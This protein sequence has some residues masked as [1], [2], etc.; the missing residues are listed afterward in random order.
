[1]REDH[2]EFLEIYYFTPSEFEK[3]GAAWPIRMGRN[4]VKPN[5]HMR[6][7][8]APCYYLIFIMDG[9]GTF[10]QQGRTYPLRKHDMFALFPQVTREYYTDQ[11]KPL[12]QIFVAFDGKLAYQLLEKIGLTPDSP[13]ISDRLNPS[14][15]RYMWDFLELVRNPPDTYTDLAR[16]G[17][18]YQIF[19]KLSQVNAAESVKDHPNVSWVH[20]GMEYME[21]HY[22]EGITVEQ[23]S[24]FVGVER[25]RF[26][27]HFRKMY[28]ETPI[29]AI[30]RLKMNEARLLL[31]QTTY[32]LS[33]VAHSVGYP[34]LFSFS[35]AFKKIVG[36][37]P[38]IY[39]LQHSGHT[40]DL[41][42]QINQQP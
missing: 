40:P 20:K 36:L 31:E 11:E 32:K 27:K 18:F 34:D 15:I 26:T 13:H 1:M 6:P 5:Y 3:S 35:K 17:K 42:Q 21:I 14:L 33:E 23:V 8:A 16:L 12:R 28:G 7:K 2:H 24:A 19:D 38:Q 41:S 10:L 30:Q 9:Q 39:R 22:A 29:Q 25:T 37:P 4:I